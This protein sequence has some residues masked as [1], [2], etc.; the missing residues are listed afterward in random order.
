MNTSNERDVVLIPLHAEYLEYLAKC[1]AKVA[2]GGKLDGIPPSAGEVVGAAL[3][4]Y[5]THDVE[6]PQ[7]ELK[8]VDTG[9]DGDD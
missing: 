1:K 2:E 7:V 8:L 9:K 3:M 5:A 4:W 6:P